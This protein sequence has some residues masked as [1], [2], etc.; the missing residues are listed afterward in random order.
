MFAFQVVGPYWEPFLHQF[1]DKRVGFG[2]VIAIQAFPAGPD[3][4]SG[5]QQSPSR[6]L[7]ILTSV[8]AIMI[9][10]AL[11][12]D[13]IESMRTTLSIQQWY[14]IENLISLLFQLIA[15][16]NRLF[17][18]ARISNVSAALVLFI[19]SYELHWTKCKSQ[20][21]ISDLVGQ[22]QSQFLWSSISSLEESART[23]KTFSTSDACS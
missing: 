1:I 14:A 8:V 3:N 15:S 11:S 10:H 16:L 5:P 19:W 13:I 9:L 21:V 6:N 12:E 23:R 17:F 22:D 4:D 18:P 20:K 2:L 7:T